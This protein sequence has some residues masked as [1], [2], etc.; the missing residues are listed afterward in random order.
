MVTETIKTG[1]WRY[2]LA[3]EAEWI[4]GNYPPRLKP[5]KKLPLTLGVPGEAKEDEEPVTPT[6]ER[7]GPLISSRELY[8]LDVQWGDWWKTYQQTGEYPTAPTEERFKPYYE[9]WLQ[10]AQQLELQP[11]EGA[12]RTEVPT[13]DVTELATLY[14]LAPHR[15]VTEKQLADLALI[16]AGE[17]PAVQWRIPYEQYLTSEQ[18]KYLGF[19]VPEGSVVKMTPMAE[20][21]PSLKLDHQN[22]SQELRKLSAML[23][24]RCSTL[25]LVGAFHLKKSQREY[26]SYMG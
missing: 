25:V 26:S 18:A 6:E 20:G 19:D 13:P 15:F 7:A 22:S 10:A 17:E 24:R 8:E 2:G 9:Q 5:R 23:S 16:L 1:Y 4:E 3:G 12:V 14:N 11:I 21:E